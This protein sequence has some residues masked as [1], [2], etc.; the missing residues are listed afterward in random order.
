[1][2]CSQKQ[3]IGTKRKVWDQNELASDQTKISIL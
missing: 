1:M 3:K 2:H